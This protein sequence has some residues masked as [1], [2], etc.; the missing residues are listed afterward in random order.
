MPQAEMPS[1][2]QPQRGVGDP[3]PG[4]RGVFVVMRACCDLLPCFM[5]FMSDAL[6]DALATTAHAKQRRQ[7]RRRHLL[8]GRLPTRQRAVALLAHAPAP[9]WGR[10]TAETSAPENR[11]AQS[12]KPFNRYD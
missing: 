5:L 10:A 3:Q 9:P 7:R 4:W 11:R 2:R 6:T 1:Q 12:G 8:T